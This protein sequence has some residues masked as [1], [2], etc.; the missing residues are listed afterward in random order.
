MLAHKALLKK[1]RE[2]FM[3]SIDP[4]MSQQMKD[5]MISDF[6]AQMNMLSAGIQRD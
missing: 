5:K 1:K 6:D 3:A 4:S 2:E